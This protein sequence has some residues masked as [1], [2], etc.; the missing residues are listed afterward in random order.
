MVECWSRRSWLLRLRPRKGR[1]SPKKSM[2]L[3]LICRASAPTK[4]LS[5][6]VKLHAPK[7]CQKVGT[8]GRSGGS[9]YLQ[10]IY[11]GN[12]PGD[13]SSNSFS[14]DLLEQQPRLTVP[15]SQASPVLEPVEQAAASATPEPVDTPAVSPSGKTATLVQPAVP[16]LEVA[17]ER[18]LPRQPNERRS[19]WRRY[20]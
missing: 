8:K 11:R 3:C 14:Q 18:Q 13:S 4:R 7:M 10:S 12:Q 19:L 16:V 2:L 5:R 17:V 20:K 15:T 9:R 1:L 6:L